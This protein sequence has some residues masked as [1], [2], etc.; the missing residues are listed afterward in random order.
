[1]KF[2]NE[3]NEIPF[4][5]RLIN[6]YFT[7]SEA[8]LHVPQSFSKQLSGTHLNPLAPADVHGRELAYFLTDS[9]SFTINISFN[10]D[11]GP[12]DVK[13]MVRGCDD[14]HCM[15]HFLFC[16]SSVPSDVFRQLSIYHFVTCCFLVFVFLLT[17]FPCK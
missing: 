2:L 4:L 1:M 17:S 5:P 14:P 12:K 13:G 6:S 9:M 8:S 15:Y 7:Q 11:S 16:L 10:V 3:I